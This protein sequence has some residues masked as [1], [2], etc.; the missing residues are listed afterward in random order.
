MHAFIPA[1]P[2]IV[3]VLATALGGVILLGFAIA[4]GVLTSSARFVGWATLLFGTLVVEWLT[5]AE[6]AGVRMLALV[7]FGL[8]A[9]KLVV[10]A[11]ERTRGMKKLSFGAWLGFAAAWPGMKP[12]PFCS[13]DVGARSG[14]GAL[15][16]RGAVHVLLGATLVLLARTAWLATHSR[17]LATA[18]LLPG[19]SL[20]LHFGVCNLLAGAW[21]RRGVA[22]EALFQAP[23]RSESLSEFWARRW[24]LAFS[25]MTAT[26]AYRP[27]ATRIGRGPALVAAFALSGLLHEMAIS[28]PVRD[29]FGLPLAYFVGHGVLVLIERALASA[30]HPLTGLTG[31][32]WAFFWLVAPLPLLFHRPFLA[33]VVWP[34]IGITPGG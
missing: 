31:R 22:C 24:N 14:A 30:G 23:L 8:L 10:V 33:F 29:C 32:V 11:E 16:R 17:L 12:G 7:T 25:E 3:V 21:R 26:V 20:C 27:L 9:M 2:W 13:P 28:L 1:D 19:L 5:R 4:R 6:P 34:L 15:L 18:L